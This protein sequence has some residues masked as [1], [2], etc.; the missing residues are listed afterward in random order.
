MREIKLSEHEIQSQI[1]EYLTLKKWKVLRLNS[2]N[3]I[4]EDKKGKI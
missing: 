1:I 4:F 2:G 3:H